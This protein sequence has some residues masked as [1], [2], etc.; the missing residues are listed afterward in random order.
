MNLVRSQVALHRALTSLLRAAETRPI[1]WRR[2]CASPRLP[3][4]D[5][6]GASSTL[7]GTGFIATPVSTSAPASVDVLREAPQVVSASGVKA[8]GN[9]LLEFGSHSP[10]CVLF[11]LCENSGGGEEAAAQAATAA[12]ELQPLLWQLL[13][14]TLRTEEEELPVATKSTRIATAKMKD[15]LDGPSVPSRTLRANDDGVGSG[16]QSGGTGASDGAATIVTAAQ[17]PQIPDSAA[18][19]RPGS[20]SS[21]EEANR[22]RKNEGATQGAAATTPTTMPLS[23]SQLLVSQGLVGAGTLVAMAQ[24]LLS[25]GAAVETRRRTARV[26]HHLW[27]AIPPEAQPEVV[28]RLAS[29]LPS[30]ARQGSRAREWLSFLVHAVADACPQP[31]TDNPIS[32]TSAAAVIM[33][34]PLRALVRAAAA[35]VEEQAGA[36]RNHPNAALYAAIGRLVPGA[37]HYL[38]LDPCLVCLEQDRRGAAGSGAP[39]GVDGGRSGAAAAAAAAAV[40]SSGSGAPGAVVSGNGAATAAGGSGGGG[41]V[42]LNYPLE[43]VKASS[44]STE[45]AM[46]V[47]V[48]YC[49]IGVLGRSMSWISVIRSCD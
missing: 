14:L 3:R 26:L 48:L 4:L 43:S 11:A 38:D 12:G 28:H 29:H 23:P 15:Q 41:S 27:A 42:F 35:A 34:S 17:V 22:H 13:E 32:T 30:A 36:L 33:N 46:L 44:K 1:N 47:R 49:T 25:P 16:S 6:A 21:S 45:N 2:Y 40:L 5:D 24:D 7:A 39:R 18:I 37:G 10:V 19:Q 20:G 8:D 9:L 31:Y